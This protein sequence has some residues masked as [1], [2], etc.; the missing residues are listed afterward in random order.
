MIF[1]RKTSIAN[2]SAKAHNYHHHNNYMYV[3]S[4]WVFSMQAGDKI[5]VSYMQGMIT[6]CRYW[7][8]SSIWIVMGFIF[9]YTVEPLLTDPPRRGQPPRR[10][11]SLMHRLM[12]LI[13]N[14]LRDRDDL[15]TRDRGNI[16]KC[17][18]LGGS[19]VLSTKR[20]SEWRTISL[21]TSTSHAPMG[22]N[23]VY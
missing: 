10:G 9:V 4:C 23:N 7:G 18:L 19:T 1:R 15:S 12:L 17:P 14:N 8:G 2:H 22:F 6:V 20:H 3:H 11:H 21:Q 16:P 13:Q 5:G